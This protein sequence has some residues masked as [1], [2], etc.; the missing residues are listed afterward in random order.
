MEE[1]RLDAYY[2]IYELNYGNKIGEN[3]NKSIFWLYAK[4]V[5]KVLPIDNLETLQ[6]DL[7]N[8]YILTSELTNFTGT[9]AAT[10][11]KFMSL[12]SLSFITLKHIKVQ[13]KELCKEQCKELCKDSKDIS[14]V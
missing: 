11:G 1:E 7:N 2:K 10:W 9:I 5:N 6:D 4:V 12:M 13:G 14:E 3:M 8:D